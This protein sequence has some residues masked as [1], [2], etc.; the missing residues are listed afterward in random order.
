MVAVDL[1]SSTKL[2]LHWRLCI[3]A[4]YTLSFGAQFAVRGGARSVCVM[5]GTKTSKGIAEFGTLGKTKRKPRI[6]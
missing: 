3:D 2:A 6:R 5:A 4:T 1:D